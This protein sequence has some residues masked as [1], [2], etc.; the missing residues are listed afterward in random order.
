MGGVE[1][2]KGTEERLGGREENVAEISEQGKKVCGF[3]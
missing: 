1:Q 2:V 3:F